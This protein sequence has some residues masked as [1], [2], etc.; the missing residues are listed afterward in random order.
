[1]VGCMHFKQQRVATRFMRALARS[2]IYAHTH[3]YTLCV[4]AYLFVLSSLA[5]SF[6]LRHKWNFGLR[7]MGP[8]T[9]FFSSHLAVVV[10]SVAVLAS[11]KKGKSFKVGHR[12]R[13]AS[14]TVSAFGFVMLFSCCIMRRL[15][16]TKASHNTHHHK[17]RHTH[18]PTKKGQGMLVGRPDCTRL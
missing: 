7:L 15:P 3:T 13:F 4:Q 12:V 14:R 8:S 9:V 16:D 6:P 2:Q 17:T 11:R 1:M 10:I 5:D 18:T